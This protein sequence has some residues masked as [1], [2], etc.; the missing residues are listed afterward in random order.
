MVTNYFIAQ[1]RKDEVFLGISGTVLGHLVFNARGS[2]WNFNNLP[3]YLNDTGDQKQF[4]IAYDN[5]KALSFHGSLRYTDANIWSIGAT[6][7]FYKYYNGTQQYVWQQPNTTIKADFTINPSPRFMVTA[8][9]AVLSGMHARDT[10]YNVVNMKPI[11]DLGAN[12]EYQVIHRLSVF[13]QINNLLDDKYERWYGPGN[14]YQSYG[15]NIYG[16]VRL[17]F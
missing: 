8:Y 6:G 13:L 1:T 11:A 9:I 17:K 2:W 3:T 4:Y 5:V 15:L 7:D 10:S 12:A 14:G 16:G